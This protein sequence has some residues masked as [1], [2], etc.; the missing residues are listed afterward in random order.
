M[1]REKPFEK[2][3]DQ[4]IELAKEDLKKDLTRIENLETEIKK[5]Y[6]NLLS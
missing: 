4:M 6:D 3:I 1:I 5:C 2:K